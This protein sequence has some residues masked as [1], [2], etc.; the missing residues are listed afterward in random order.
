MCALSHSNDPDCSHLAQTCRSP[1]GQQQEVL[2]TG[3]GST[4]QP[5]YKQ[6]RKC[7]ATQEDG[8]KDAEVTEQLWKCREIAGRRRMVRKQTR[9]RTLCF[10]L[11]E[12]AKKWNELGEMMMG[13]GRIK[14][15]DASRC[16]GWSPRGPIEPL[17]DPDWQINWP[18]GD[19]K[20]AGQTVNNAASHGQNTQ[21]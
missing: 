4:D 19:E 8:G 6:E 14:V 7:A 17:V 3:H 1:R 9:T 15:I 2:L 12:E 5:I 16:C 18:R 20:P 13:E 21:L 10:K 11:Q